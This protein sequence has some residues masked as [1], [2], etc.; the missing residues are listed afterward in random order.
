M[1]TCA[2]VAAETD[3]CGNLYPVNVPV[4]FRR[5]SPR[6]VSLAAV[7]VTLAARVVWTVALAVACLL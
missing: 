5:P 1:A 2:G 4:E 3:C 7:A 6:S